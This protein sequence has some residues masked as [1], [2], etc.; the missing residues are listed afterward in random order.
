MTSAARKAAEGLR[1]EHSSEFHLHGRTLRSASWRY[2][3]FRLT[4]ACAPCRC[5]KRGVA[6]PPV[7]SI[8]RHWLSP[9]MI[10]YAETG[11]TEV[12]PATSAQKPQPTNQCTL[13]RHASIA[14]RLKYRL[15]VACRQSL[16]PWGKRGL[17]SCKHRPPFIVSRPINSELS[18]QNYRS[19][20]PGASL[21]QQLRL[22]PILNV[23]VEENPPVSGTQREVGSNRCQS[24]GLT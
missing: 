15:S 10:S 20:V 11:A 6:S 14:V 13:A 23:A 9:E 17:S 3:K 5:L 7:C 8:S 16:P 24:P 12:A 1:L 21:R 19:I 22:R 18:S 4:P 2:P